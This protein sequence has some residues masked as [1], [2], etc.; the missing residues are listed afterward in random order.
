MTRLSLPFD[1]TASASVSGWVDVDAALDVLSA[2]FGVS[3]LWG[4][5]E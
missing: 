4:I 3:R 2:M 5:A 1:N